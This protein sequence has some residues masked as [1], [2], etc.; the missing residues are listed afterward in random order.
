MARNSERSVS[1][2]KREAER[3]RSDLRET[4]GELH[5]TVNDTVED[6]RARVSPNAIKAEVGD[7]FRTRG[8]LLMEKARENPIQTAAI[9]A[10]LAYALLGVARSIPAPVLMVGAGL[11][12]LGTKSGQNLTQTASQKARAA[13]DGL[14]DIIGSGTDALKENIHNAQDAASQ[15][16][17]SA[18]AAFAT[19]VDGLK[20]QT[21]YASERV[22]DG[23][24]QIKQK[25]SDLA[26]SARAG[27]GEVRQSALDAGGIARETVGTA[28][29]AAQR[30]AAGAVDYGASTARHLQDGAI[31]V[32][33][34]TRTVATQTIQDN[35]LLV[36]GVG[37]AIGMLIASV[38]P[39]SD[40]ETGLM[41]AASLGVQKRAGDMASQ[42][43]DAAKDIVTTAFNDG[44]DQAE[45]EGLTQS[46]V[47]VAAR[48]LGSRVRKVVENATTAAFELAGE[49]ASS[50]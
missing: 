16:L 21:S 30:A 47:D 8:E 22:S 35:P 29:S 46:D 45:R 31:D 18:Q 26:D 38:L 1:D 12:L 4:V 14:S 13:A 40:V 20:R 15:S 39:K 49:P 9:G 27:I 3:T 6:F 7:Y 48:D 2:L 37:L 41:G 19:G 36:G 32:A 11:F 24:G 44:A 33:Q 5:S 10:G 43:F 34:R 25:A 28:S 42:G 50:Q 17:D 23:I